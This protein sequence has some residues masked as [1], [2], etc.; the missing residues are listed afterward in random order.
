[1]FLNDLTTRP[2]VGSKGSL[3]LCTIDIDKVMTSNGLMK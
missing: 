2:F 3:S 1:M